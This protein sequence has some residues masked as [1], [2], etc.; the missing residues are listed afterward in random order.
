MKKHLL[1]LLLGC[2]V[3]CGLTPQQVMVVYNADSK[4]SKETA[5]QYAS[6]RSIPAENLVPLKGITKAHLTRTRFVLDIEQ[7][8]VAEA[9][10][11]GWMLPSSTAFEPR[12]KHILALVLMPDFPI[13]ILEDKLDP[14]Q[15]KS[16]QLKNTASLDSELTLLGARYPID[17]A[18]YNP[19]YT[20][21]A[22]LQQ[23]RPRV[24]A[25]TRIDAPS[26]EAIRR[27]IQD[28]VKV[29]K[30]GL[31]GWTVVDQGGPY[32]AGDKWFAAAANH[33]K[34]ANQALFYETSKKTLA[35]AFPLMPQTSV[36]FGWYA[37][38]ANGPFHPD[39]AGDFRFAPG[40]IACHLHSYSASPSVRTKTSWVGAMLERGAAVTAG[41][42]DEPYLGHCLNYDVFYD[43]L[44]KGYTVAEAGLMAS[45][46]LSWQGAIYGD[47]LY[48]PYAALK[49]GIHTVDNPFAVWRNILQGARGN[50]AQILRAVQ[51]RLTK[52]DGAVYAE[53]FAWYCLE[54]NME[55]GASTYFS[56]ASRAAKSHA[57]KL[58]NRLMQISTMFSFGDKD[59]AKALMRATLQENSTS[60]HAPAVEALADVVIKEERPAPV[61]K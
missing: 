48:R 31:W 24:L 57:D 50:T 26:P 61:K 28:P 55:Q 44:L 29:E 41:N 54:N 14:R 7:R 22:S 30:Q 10:S 33:A 42:V 52:P 23:A 36:Y 43:R 46:S 35:T 20:K 17:G 53:M 6:L 47:P 19:F 15:K 3:A 38:P 9:E 59:A 40:A 45:P 34:A 16:D 2:S 51:Q 32:A 27:M 39:A 12:K 13:R 5:L 49:K 58:R 18:L 56:M 11:K 60:P 37:H 1:T 8:L 4:I 25:V 21:D